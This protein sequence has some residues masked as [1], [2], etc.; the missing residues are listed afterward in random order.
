ML[1]ADG[2]PADAV[3]HLIQDGEPSRIAAVRGQA[4]VLPR[5]QRLSAVAAAGGS[6]SQAAHW[7]EEDPGNAELVLRLG[8]ARAA[9]LTVEASLAGEGP[10]AGARITALGRMPRNGWE[11]LFEGL[12]LRAPDR[13]PP[14]AGT[15]PAANA[16][17]WKEDADRIAR[18]SLMR[19]AWVAG[20][21]GVARIEGLRAGDWA[22]E[23]RAPGCPP[24]YFERS[25][26]A[27]EDARE[28]VTL[29]R[30]GVVAGRVT[31][32]GGAAV[33]GT[34]VGLWPVVETE[35]TFFSPVE[36]FLRYGRMPGA[37]PAELR[38]TCGAD[39]GFEIGAV[40][41][42]EWT[43]LALAP[44]LRP[45]QSRAVELQRNG[46]ADAGEL[47]LTRGHELSVR[48]LNPAGVPVSGARVAWRAGET[49]MGMLT[50]GSS[51]QETGGDG[52][53]VIQA[54]PS[55]GVEVRV[56]HG[57][58]A[59]EKREFQFVAGTEALG[60]QWEV[61]LRAGAALT[62]TVLAAGAPVEDARVRLLPP[63]EGSG[64]LAAVLDAEADA[65]SGADG[66]FRLERIPP[67]TWRLTVEHPDYARLSTSPF[68]LAEGENP[69]RLLHL[70]RGGTI[71]VTVLDD[72]GAPVE[73]AVVLAQETAD[74]QSETATS[75]PDGIARLER[76][77]AADWRLMRVDQFAG[78]DP[79]NL[80]LDMKFVFVSLDEGETEE[81]T[82]GGPVERADVSG[83][84]TMGGRPLAKH[85]VTL[86]GNGGV[87][88]TRSEEDG[89]YAL[90][91][92]ELGDYIFSVAT[93]FGGGSSWFGSLELDRS[94]AVRHDV[95][96]PDAAV[97]VRVVDARTGQPLS[98]VPVNLRPEDASSVSGGAFQHSD[99][100]GVA[101]FHMLEQGGY[102]AAVGSLAMPMLGGGEGHGTVVIEG[103]RV[104]SGSGVQRFE[105]RLPEPAQLRVRVS[106][107]DGEYLAGAHVH[108]LAASGQTLNFFSM[109]ATNAKGVVELSG[110][111]PG[112][113]RFLVRH[114]RVGSTEFEATLAAG[115]LS[116]QEV[117]LG[118]GVR[119]EVSVVGADGAPLAGVLAV[120][121][122]EKGVPQFFFSVEDSQ[123]VNQAWFSG[124]AQPIGP[125]T[126]GRYVIRLN[127][128]GQAPV[129]HPVTVAPAPEVQQVRLRYAPE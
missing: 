96:V 112:T 55:G 44:G 74:F 76:L 107:P 60:K 78:T 82:L 117:T 40:P 72:D 26:V 11:R 118:H 79:S 64:M 50:E 23:V 128:P 5:P 6:W 129:D 27:G 34:A 94:G 22:F 51:P 37:V 80:R 61:T 57:A 71:V 54:L 43:V 102:L 39:G 14:A 97:E 103:I 67:G 95:E 98:G 13:D 115:E 16:G 48:V 113:Q 110:L 100:E 49:M 18:R 19:E 127:R 85:T 29:E 86:V 105:A 68:E 36:D 91:G 73:K 75:G 12:A 120:A 28:P 45:L 8:D 83:M 7:S 25:L 90:E 56:E 108:C 114:P 42:G 4:Q 31:G 104:A 106:G 77:P 41:A 84:L 17:P 111:P 70:V 59:R 121:L 87:R 81:V 88:T 9:A 47:R 38:A 63:R 10:A 24:A 126:P 66:G 109:K 35:M 1:D 3:L 123:E 58:Y 99:A 53:A 101:A 21:D 15:R 62:G 32:P 89:S 116:K 93:G 20:D 124:G 33:A 52:V 46:R 119:L 2:R 69:P 30:G 122:N 125:L 92:V 65:A